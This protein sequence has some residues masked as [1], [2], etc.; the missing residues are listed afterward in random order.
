LPACSRSGTSASSPTVSQAVS[1]ST[2][3]AKASDPG[4][5]GPYPV[6]V[7]EI[8]FQRASTT[9]GEPRIL[10]TVV[11]YPAAAGAA[12]ESPD[13]TY[14]GVT[15]AEPSPDG[16][17]FPIIMFS[18]GSGGTPLQ[19]TFYT[20]HLAS[21]GFVVVA[22]PHPGNT[23]NDCL[24]CVDMQALADSL[25]NRPDDIT[26]VLDS[27]L[28][29]NDDPSSLFYGA[30]DGTRVGMSGH[31]FGGL[32]TLQLAGSDTTPF[33]AALAM[34]PPAAAVVGRRNPSNIPIMLMGGG[35]DTTCPL[36]P[37]EDYFNALN[38][39]EPRFLVVFP[40]G[41]HTAYTDPCVPL[42][43]A[44][45]PAAID[46]GKAHELIDFYATAFFKTYVAGDERYAAYLDPK[47]AAGDADLQYEA[48]V[49]N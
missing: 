2:P 17:P 40:R 32:T 38:G 21:Q 16:G 24:P 28:K 34:A 46:Q 4:A 36:G 7:T 35:E 3:L 1:A 45:G 13:T 19:S 41:G 29:L 48:H 26:F 11:W 49:P 44:C 18:H 31:S 6:G 25:L 15:D 12:N 5:P 22:P 30:L 10:K 14:K 37:Q 9:T 27:M 8:T 33:A 20:S 39:S 23:I 43:D 47:L 42:I